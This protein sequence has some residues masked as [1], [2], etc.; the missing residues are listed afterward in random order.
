MNILDIEYSFFILFA[1]IQHLILHHA[2]KNILHPFL[3]HL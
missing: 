3:V 1:K 2:R